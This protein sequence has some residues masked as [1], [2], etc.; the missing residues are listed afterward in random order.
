M[1]QEC[2]HVVQ[3]A[4]R[5]AHLSKGLRTATRNTPL[6]LFF[7]LLSLCP[8]TA[9]AGQPGDP[10][11]EFRESIRQTYTFKPSRLSPA[12]QDA[13]SKAMD[14]IWES[15]KANPKRALP[16]LRAAL[17]DPASDPWFRFDG[18]SL[19][20]QLDPS[21]AAKAI[22]VREFTAVD[23]D[24]VNLRVWVQTLARRGT[25]GFDVSEAGARWL[26]YPKASYSLP[27]HGGYRVSKSN[28]AL[29]IYGSM[30]ESQAT[31]ALFKIVS[32]PNHPG[33]E[34]ALW[35]L[36][37]QAT[38]EALRLLKQVDPRSFSGPPQ[39]NLTALLGQP[40]LLKPRPGTPR[41][42][43][44]EYLDAFQAIVSKNSWKEFQALVERVPDGEQDT[45][46]V[47]KPEDLPLLRRVRRLRI[48]H[49]NQHAIEYYNEFTAILM[50]LT[51]R[52]DLVK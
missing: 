40:G 42:S 18:S 30:D 47:L 8:F 7:P 39:R 33:R 16:C 45:V 6:I 3:V 25:E 38:P 48:A 50:A 49:A 1:P 21:P 52:A 27:D 36:M 12:E 13:R 23:L 46:A 15:A 5:K 41:V 34:D 32:Q 28:G 10:C 37:S 24:D 29:F 11:A 35:L 19:L 26:A 22:Q 43:R 17:E 44:R 4:S 51:W 14:R 9:A 2:P 20:V 31:P